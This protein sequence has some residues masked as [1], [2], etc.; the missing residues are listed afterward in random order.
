MHR[1]LLGKDLMVNRFDIVL[2]L[3]INIEHYQ[4]SMFY[5]WGTDI[6]KN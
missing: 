6:P 2:R 3:A 1:V 5:S 4:L